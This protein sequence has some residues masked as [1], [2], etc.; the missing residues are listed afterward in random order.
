MTNPLM[1][2]RCEKTMKKVKAR[3]KLFGITTS[4]VN[5]YMSKRNP[6]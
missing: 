4:M 6:R 3:L 1:A 2:K 5:E